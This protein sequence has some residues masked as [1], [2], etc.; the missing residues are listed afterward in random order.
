MYCLTGFSTASGTLLFPSKFDFKISFTLLHWLGPLSKSNR[1]GV[2]WGYLGG[3]RGVWS[4]TISGSQTFL[5]LDQKQLC[6][7]MKFFDTFRQYTSVNLISTFG[8]AFFRQQITI[9]QLFEKYFMI[10]YR[11][12]YK[13][14]FY[15]WNF[16]KHFG[17][18]NLISML[19]INYN[20]T[21][22]FL[23]IS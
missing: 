6:S 13:S 16:A 8:C 3:V 1:L 12:F 9:L 17:H 21:L 2:S 11:K 7:W 15:Y 22:Y 20:F 5:F 19:Q 4:I 10:F 23:K 18:E 14:C